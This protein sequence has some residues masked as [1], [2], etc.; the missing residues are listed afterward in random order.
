VALRVILLLLLAATPAI[1]DRAFIGM[2]DAFVV[3]DGKTAKRPFKSPRFAL[4][5]AQAKADTLWIG[6]TLGVHRWNAG[7]LDEKLLRTALYLRVVNDVMWLGN[8][9]ELVWFDT[10]WNDLAIPGATESLRDLEVDDQ[11]RAWILLGERLLYTKGDKWTTVAGPPDENLLYCKLA[12]RGELY[13]ACAETVYRFASNTWKSVAKHA[14]VVVEDVYVGNAI[15]VV[16]GGKLITEH[17]VI[18]LPRWK[19]NGFVVDA[20]GRI[21]LATDGGLTVLDATGKKLKLPRALATKDRV[22]AIYV[23]GAGPK[24]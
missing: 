6:S 8:Q 1:A 10:Q 22:H 11:G 17:L 14:R 13:V 20:S 5:I 15:Y 7:K 18:E 19:L 3:Y 9:K 21:W 12:A 4:H 24:L 23:E 16:G 2:H